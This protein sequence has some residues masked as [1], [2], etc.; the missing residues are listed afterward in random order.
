MENKITKGF[1]MVIVITTIAM[2]GSAMFFLT[3][4]SST[5]M[6]QA[7]DACLNACQ[8]NLITSGIA[9]AKTKIKNQSER[10]LNIPTE[11]NVTELNIQHA[12]LNVTVSVSSNMPPK[13]HISTSCSRGRQYLKSDDTYQI[14]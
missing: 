14:E 9:W 5:M 2:I 7:D 12:D 4:A 3:N 1:A 8:Q 10:H 13:V 11:L 6:F